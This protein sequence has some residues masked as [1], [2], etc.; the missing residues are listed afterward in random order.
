M[1][2]MGG[3]GIGG[4]TILFSHVISTFQSLQ[5]YAIQGRPEVKQKNRGGAAVWLVG[6]GSMLHFYVQGKSAAFLQGL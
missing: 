1:G 2:K 5:A 6:G 4:H 3:G